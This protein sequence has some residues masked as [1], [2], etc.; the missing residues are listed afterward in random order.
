MKIE[1]I[2]EDQKVTYA[3]YMLIGDV[4]HWW[5]RIR[6]LLQAQVV[7][8]T[9]MSFRASFLKKYFPENVRNQKEIEFLQLKQGGMTVDQYTARFDELAKFSTYL[10]NA[11]DK[12]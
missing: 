1:K 6:A 7:P 10:R 8:P 4:E 12:A 9:W 5:R 11:L 2:F 3:T